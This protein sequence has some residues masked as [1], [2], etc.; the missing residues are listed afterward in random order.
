ME[1]R[2]IYELFK[3]KSEK[4]IAAVSEKY[5]RYCLAIAM[6]ILGNAEDA[7]ECVND[8]WL[9]FWASVPEEEPKNL[10]LLLAKITR[11]FAL[12]R[13]NAEKR[14][15][16]G[17]SEVCLALE[18]INEFVSG[19]D[20]TAEKVVQAELM[21]AI[22]SFLR[23]LPERECGIFINRYFKLE[24]TVHIAEMYGVTESNVHKI[25]SRTRT[26]LKNYLIKEGYEI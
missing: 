23:G 6:H 11:N 1:D 9:A 21:A 22:N 24:T 25:L 5:G 16:R 15:K 20:N 2:E 18:E 19:E 26:K 3:C 17:G 4:A 13:Y 8:T 14:E 12:N 7:E 10:K